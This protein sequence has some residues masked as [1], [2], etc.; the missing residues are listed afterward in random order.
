MSTDEFQG[1]IRS[2]AGKVVNRDQMVDGVSD[3][4]E[5]LLGDAHVGGDQAMSVTHG[6]VGDAQSAAKREPEFLALD[7]VA[8]GYAAAWP[9]H[10]RR[11]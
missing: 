10:A 4:H 5:R 6:V 8:P 11:D 3:L 1:G 9:I 2:I 7:A